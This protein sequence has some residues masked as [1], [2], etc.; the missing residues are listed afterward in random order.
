MV[1]HTILTVVTLALAISALVVIHLNE[2]SEQPPHVMCEGM[3]GADGMR[4]LTIRD[5]GW[6][7]SCYEV[8]CE[9][10]PG[11]D[12]ETGFT[13]GDISEAE[14]CYRGIGETG[15]TDWHIGI[16]TVM[17]IIVG[18][19]AAITGVRLMYVDREYAMI[20]RHHERN[21]EELEG[22]VAESNGV[23]QNIGELW[24]QHNVVTK[25]KADRDGN[26]R[27]GIMLDMIAIAGMIV[28]GLLGSGGVFTDVLPMMFVSI[29]LFV[30]PTSHF[31][32]H[33][34]NVTKTSL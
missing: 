4:G 6:A 33:I 10:L 13:E 2:P 27:E 26:R 14:M 20:I 7:A 25:T 31:M 28:L 22:K 32:R 11:A 16:F 3:S 12:G 30:F 9:G 15:Q 17:A 19:V 23:D 8:F 1:T 21:I 24:S 18:L 5:E 34:K 29:I